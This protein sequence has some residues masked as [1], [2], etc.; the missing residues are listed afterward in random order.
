MRVWR[1]RFNSRLDECIH[2]VIAL[3]F[4]DVLDEQRLELIDDYGEDLF[5]EA[6]RI[7]EADYEGLLKRIL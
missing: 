1:C 2:L 7:V 3:C 6:V 5:I 4:S